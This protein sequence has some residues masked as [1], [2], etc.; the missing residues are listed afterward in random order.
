MVNTFP[1]SLRFARSGSLSPIFIH[2][3]VG[4]GLQHETTCYEPQSQIYMMIYYSD[5]V[6]IYTYYPSGIHSSCR[7]SPFSSTF[8]VWTPEGSS[9]PGN[10]ARGAS[11]ALNT[12]NSLPQSYGSFTSMV[13]SPTQKFIVNLSSVAFWDMSKNYC[14]ACSHDMRC[15]LIHTVRALMCEYYSLADSLPGFS[16]TKTKH[17]GNDA[18]S[19][20]LSSPTDKYC[21][22]QCQ[23][24]PWAQTWQGKPCFLVCSERIV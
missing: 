11:A 1:K 5:N 4:V 21:S 9:R 17:C 2:F 22:I 24:F 7:F 16:G 12:E 23:K 13:K 18:G 6:M 14:V 8:S 10:L 3:I 20:G 15:V 19:D